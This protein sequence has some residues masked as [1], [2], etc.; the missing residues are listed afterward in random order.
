MNKTKLKNLDEYAQQ[1]CTSSKLAGFCKNNCLSQSSVTQA[2]D[3]PWPVIQANA[4]Y[5]CSSMLAVS[6]DQHIS[7]LYYSQVIIRCVNPLSFLLNFS[8]L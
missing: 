7:A 8:K 5:L 3:A 1:K 4:V 2:F 6:E